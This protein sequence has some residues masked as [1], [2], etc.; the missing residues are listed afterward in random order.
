MVS[1]QEQSIV[2]SS[3]FGGATADTSEAQASFEDKKGD[4]ALLALLKEKQ[5]PD[6]E[7]KGPV[8]GLLYFQ[9]EGKHKVKH[10]ELVYRKAPPRVHLRF[11]EPKKK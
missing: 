8:E 3:S 2:D 4:K 1:R 6:G 5:L 7:L 9:I 10:F 11:V